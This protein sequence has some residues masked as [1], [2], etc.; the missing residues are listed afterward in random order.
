M[1]YELFQYINGLA[2]HNYLWDHIFE[3][4]TSYGFYLCVLVLVIMALRQST[5]IAAI[6]GFVA[7]CLAMGINFLIGLVYNRPRPFVTYHVHLLLPH[8]PDASFPSD[9]TAVAVAIAVSLWFYNRKVGLPMFILA[10]L[11]GF[12]RIYVGHHYPTDVLGGMVVGALS[13]FIINKVGNKLLKHNSNSYV[14]DEKSA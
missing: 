2:G 13:A 10:F 11:I 14:Q 7:P 9:H 6:C 3:A 1:D 8:D 4:F 5:R 12:S